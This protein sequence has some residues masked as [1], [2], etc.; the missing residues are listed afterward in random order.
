MDAQG[1]KGSQLF[2]L[3]IKENGLPA[4][5]HFHTMFDLQGDAWFIK[6]QTVFFFSFFAIHR[7]LKF[8]LLH[9]KEV[10]PALGIRKLL[11]KV[12]E[13]KTLAARH[14]LPA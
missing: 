4:R 10:F 9:L 14:W 2:S 6:G 13:N 12:E 8:P 5:S 7:L 3:H 11:L 1:G